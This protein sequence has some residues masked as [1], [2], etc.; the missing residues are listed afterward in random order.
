MKIDFLLCYEHWQREL[1]ALTILRIRL[2]KYGYK[3]RM[4]NITPGFTEYLEN[5]LYEPKVVVFPWVYGNRELHQAINFK[6]D[7]PIVVNMQSEQLLSK[8]IINSGFFS[9]KGHAIEAYHVS[10]GEIT[11]RRYIDWGVDNNHILEVGNINLEI[12]KKSYDDYYKSKAEL[13]EEFDINYNNKWLLYISNFKFTNTD[14]H[15]LDEMDK[16]SPNIFEL[17][18]QM[19]KS[20]KKTLKWLIDIAEKN[21]DIEIIYRPHPVEISDSYLTFL[22]D[23]YHNFHYVDEDT[24]NQWVRV[25]SWCVTWNS[26]GIVDAVMRGVPSVMLKP[27]DVPDILKGD[28]DYVCKEI[29]TLKQL[30]Q[31]IDDEGGDCIDSNYEHI[32]KLIRIDNDSIDELVDKLIKLINDGDNVSTSRNDLGIKS[33]PAKKSQ[34]IGLFIKKK[35]PIKKNELYWNITYLE[36]KLYVK[37]REKKG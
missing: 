29:S 23:K 37:F 12:S 10:W 6:G 16:R 3:V 9:I 8:R 7:A 26:T 34:M 27:Y 19:I 15:I 4:L 11:T 32:K 2:E 18:G 36:K 35:L 28:T 30:Q 22:A 31:F 21:P 24:I 1:T 13:G 14:L 17:A 33:A 25:S 5:Y 20:K